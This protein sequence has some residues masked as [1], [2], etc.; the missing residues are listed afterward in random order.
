M[1]VLPL[2]WEMHRNCQKASSSD[3]LCFK[4]EIKCC[5]VLTVGMKYDLLYSMGE[6]N[7]SAENQRPCVLRGDLSVV[8][9]WTPVT[10][11]AMAAPPNSF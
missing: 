9:S 8:F 7:Y 6:L 2:P 5:W 1:E 3:I 11:F 4:S 10:N